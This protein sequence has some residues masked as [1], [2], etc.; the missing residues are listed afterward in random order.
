MVTV[1]WHLLFTYT[2]SYLH[3]YCHDTLQL[4]NKHRSRH[5]LV[6]SLRQLERVPSKNRPDEVRQ[7]LRPKPKHD[8]CLFPELIT[9][10][11][12]RAQTEFIEGELTQKNTRY[13]VYV[14]TD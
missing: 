9:E 10:Q 4:S 12:T 2:H 14:N 6:G 1:E 7:F 5:F 13:L 3:F 11:D 8:T